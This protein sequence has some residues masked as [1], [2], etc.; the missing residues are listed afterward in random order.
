MFQT[1]ALPT[2]RFCISTWTTFF[3]AYPVYNMHTFISC[4]LVE[5]LADSPTCCFSLF[6]SLVFGMI[7]DV[8]NCAAAA[9]RRSVWLS[10][11]SLA[12]GHVPAT[13][14]SLSIISQSRPNSRPAGAQGT[15]SATWVGDRLINET[16]TC[17]YCASV[18]RRRV[19][20]NGNRPMWNR[21]STCWV[22]V[23]SVNC[24]VH[25]HQKHLAI[26]W[27][28]QEYAVRKQ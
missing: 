24:P 7:F 21:S 18:M 13:A 3:L 22:H 15:Q 14:A 23:L 12:S 20:S 28:S 10:S 5:E 8:V 4:N 2:R 6:C 16:T 17:I 11:E 27:R 9:V 1:T 26:W 19:G 25:S